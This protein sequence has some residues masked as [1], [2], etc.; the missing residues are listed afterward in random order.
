[1]S[2]SFY[3]PE[4][5]RDLGFKSIGR[6]VLISR[7][8]RFY[9]AANMVLGNNVRIDDF[10]LLSGEITLG[11]HI[12]ISAYCALYGGG[13]IEIGDYSGLSPRCSLFSATDDFSGDYLIGP[14]NQKEHT[15]VI[16]GKIILNRF[17]QLG[18]NTVVLPRVEFGEGSVTGAMSL[19]NKSTAPWS[20][21]AG[22]PARYIKDRNNKLLNFIDE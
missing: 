11:N 20:I 22:S 14:Q 2:N 15:R 21:Y 19:V 17:C 3:T 8:A 7:F 16:Q 6:D 12:H 5:L 13:G 18:A 4:E 9:G 10:C 1:M